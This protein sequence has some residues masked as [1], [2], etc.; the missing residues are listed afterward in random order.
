V[1]NKSPISHR[2]VI[3]DLVAGLWLTDRKRAEPGFGSRCARKLVRERRGMYD[4]RHDV[5]VV[6][7][8][9]RLYRRDRYPVEREQR[10][11]EKEDDRQVQPDD[12]LEPPI[13]RT[14]NPSACRSSARRSAIPVLAASPRARGYLRRSQEFCAS[15]YCLFMRKFW[16][17]ANAR[18]SLPRRYS[19]AHLQPVPEGTPTR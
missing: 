4:E 8:G 6:E 13:A 11:H 16:F 2:M 7:L 9:I 17:M 19:D 15:K 3:Y 5:L 1:S 14:I 10:H 18:Q 12:T